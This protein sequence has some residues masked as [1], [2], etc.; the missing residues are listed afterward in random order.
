MTNFGGK[1]I[2]YYV[3]TRFSYEDRLA[4]LQH[5]YLQKTI[6]LTMTLRRRLIMIFDG[7]L[8]TW[9]SPLQAYGP[10]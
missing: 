4:T 1:R 9:W 3:N 2:L 10:I 6:L 7:T 5:A 8:K